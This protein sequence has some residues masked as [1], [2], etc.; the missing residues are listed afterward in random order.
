MLADALMEYLTV[1]RWTNI[2]LVIGGDP[3]DKDYAGG[4]AQFGAQIPHQDR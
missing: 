2:A 1:K 3:G 4:R